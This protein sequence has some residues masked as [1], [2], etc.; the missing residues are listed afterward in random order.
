VGRV[1]GVA[2]GAVEVCESTGTTTQHANRRNLFSAMIL[3]A[4]STKNAHQVW[5]GTIPIKSATI[6]KLHS[7]SSAGTTKALTRPQERKPPQ[8]EDNLAIALIGGI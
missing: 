2:D 6:H 8:N 3:A 1:R 5:S 7:K 4:A